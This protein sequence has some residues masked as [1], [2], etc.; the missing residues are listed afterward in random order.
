[1]QDGSIAHYYSWSYKYNYNYNQLSLFIALQNTETVPM[2]IS[3]LQLVLLFT[4][5][6]MYMSHNHFTGIKYGTVHLLCHY[7]DS[8]TQFPVQLFTVPPPTGYPLLAPLLQHYSLHTSLCQINTSYCILFQY[9][10]SHL[11]LTQ[12]Y[13]HT[14][15]KSPFIKPALFL[16]LMH[17]TSTT[18]L[19][20]P[21]PHMGLPDT[22][23][24]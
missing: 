9:S 21:V 15:T 10:W 16:E 17:I 13:I 24:R 23:R 2:E 18:Y 1:M 6:S 11:L 4:F 20:L 7:T 8:I 3:V 12:Q 5:Q 14:A 19:L 22:S